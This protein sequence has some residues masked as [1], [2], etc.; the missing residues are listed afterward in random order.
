MKSFF[1]KGI[2]PAV[3]RSPAFEAGDKVVYQSHDM[4]AAAATG[5]ERKATVVKYIESDIRPPIYQ[6]RLS[7]GSLVIAYEIE[8]STV[9]AVKSGAVK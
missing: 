9:A 6:I 3:D 7:N 1:G 4:G 8:L 2:V 5:K